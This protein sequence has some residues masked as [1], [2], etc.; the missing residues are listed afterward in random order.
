VAVSLSSIYQDVNSN[1]HIMYTE[2][3]AATLEAHGHIEEERVAEAFDRLDSDDT[4]FISKDNL[5]EILGK[6]ANA[7]EIDQLIS[8]FDSDNDGQLSYKEFLVMFRQRTSKLLH[9]VAHLDSTDLEGAEN[10]IGLDA[11]I[12]G[13]R[14]DSTVDEKLKS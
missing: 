11:K 14:F 5:R 13:G 10:L 1:G 6:D 8:E 2:F 3:V 7:T 4:G 12:P 9:Q